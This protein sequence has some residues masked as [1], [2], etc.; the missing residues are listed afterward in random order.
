MK[1]R[2]FTKR[3]AVLWVLAASVVI[4][5]A[6]YFIAGAGKADGAELSKAD[7]AN[8]IASDGMKTGDDGNSGAPVA[9]NEEN[10]VKEYLRLRCADLLSEGILT[11]ESVRIGDILDN[12]RYS[13]LASALKEEYADYLE[14]GDFPEAFKASEIILEYEL[15]VK[16]GEADKLAELIIAGIANNGNDID[17]LGMITAER[18]SELIK[19][20]IDKGQDGVTFEKNL[21]LTDREVVERIVKAVTEEDNNSDERIK[22][23]LD[24]INGDDVISEEHNAVLREYTGGDGNQD[25][26]GSAGAEAGY[27]KIMSFADI[28]GDVEQ[29]LRKWSEGLEME[30]AGIFK[31]YTDRINDID[32]Y[33]SSLE[34][35]QSYIGRRIDEL[36]GAKEKI[37]ALDTY[38][39]A[40]ENETRTDMEGLEEEGRARLVQL[41]SDMEALIARVQSEGSEDI[42]ESNLRIN[43]LS[44]LYASLDED[45]ISRETLILLENNIKSLIES[46]SESADEEIERLAGSVLEN[47][48]RLESIEDEYSRL[49]ARLCEQYEA[50]TA[51]MEQYSDELRE[52]ISRGDQALEKKIEESSGNLWEKLQENSDDIRKENEDNSQRLHNE[53]YETAQQLQKDIDD[54]R[55]S[56]TNNFS[57]LRDNLGNMSLLL[58]EEKN[59]IVS[60]LNEVFLYAGEGKRLIADILTQ[61][62]VVTDS[63]ESFDKLADNITELAGNKFNEGIAA[64]DARCNSE[65]Q[66]YKS[67]YESGYASGSEEGYKTGSE[68]GYKSGK[69]EGYKTGSEEGYKS[70]KEEG[71]KT[72]SEEGYKTGSEEGYKTGY[73]KGYSDGMSSYKVERIDLYDLRQYDGQGWLDS[74]SY[75]IGKGYSQVYCQLDYAWLSEGT[76]RFIADYEYSSDTGILN[77][78]FADWEGPR[79][80]LSCMEKNASSHITIIAIK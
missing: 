74:I 5:A 32:D 11:E 30:F 3:V 46:E 55:E 66:S 53:I 1:I 80:A 59:D 10:M 43:E 41:R 77:V 23:L 40:L 19:D 50:V 12:G 17:A 54:D 37:A 35:E 7:S 62:G 64:A 48:G 38:M 2:K 6:A 76:T 28:S 61:A 70:G 42:S 45:K 20:I 34:S 24:R 31:Q 29:L 47:A 79:I 9:G 8:S 44:G 22:R 67:G 78:S 51:G 13:V 36:E 21:A 25:I 18:I 58:T 75:N 52:A 39:E 72:G 4:A 27:Y 73:E 57:A 60:A 14:N 33:V 15:S 49:D 68:E 26:S 71:Y 65:S 56:V 16:E 69:E 63:K